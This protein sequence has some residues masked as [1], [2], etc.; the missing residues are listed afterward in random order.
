MLEEYSIVEIKSVHNNLFPTDGRGHHEL[1][2]RLQTATR[3]WWFLSLLPWV[4]KLKLDPS[5]G[6]RRGG[7]TRVTQSYVD[8]ITCTCKLGRNTEF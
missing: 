4:H 6:W 1:C 7:V 2:I 3:E 8:I 5:L